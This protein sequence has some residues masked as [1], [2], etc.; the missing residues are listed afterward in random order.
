[1]SNL[2]KFVMIAVLMTIPTDSWSK[3][4]FVHYAKGKVYVI[5]DGQKMEL[6]EK[7]Y[8]TDKD[9]LILESGSGLIL[10][11]GKQKKLPII[12]G[13]QENMLR[14]ILKE[15]KNSFVE[16][17][18]F[19]SEFISFLFGKSHS[20]ARAAD[21]PMKATGSITRGY[22]VR[23]FD[24]NKEVLTT[25]ASKDELLDEMERYFE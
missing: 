25:H 2:I 18:E 8:L 7:Q 14:R 12:K 1:M 5:R 15:K 20:E 11:S 10:L 24:E 9:Y 23:H 4:Y 22:K 21:D 19:S 6:R 3:Q 13:P 16:F 17:V